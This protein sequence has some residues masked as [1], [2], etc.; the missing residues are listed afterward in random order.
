MS[1]LIFG[2]E[3]EAKTLPP[4][5]IREVFTTEQ[6]ILLTRHMLRVDIPDN[7]DK[8]EMVKMFVP[9]G[10]Q[11]LGTGTNRIAFLYNNLVIKLHL[12]VE[13][14]SITVQSFVG[15]LS[16]LCIWQRPMSQIF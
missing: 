2:G 3:E 1:N 11:E 7:N 10:F 13:A 5:L 9:R 4:N 6:L 16:F 14:W 15:L 8:A 12:T